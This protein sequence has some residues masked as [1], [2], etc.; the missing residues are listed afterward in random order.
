MRP[1]IN[2]AEIRYYT[3]ILY[4]FSQAKVGYGKNTLTTCIPCPKK[5]SR[6]ESKSS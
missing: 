6:A 5:L 1:V 2:F 3:A 4:T